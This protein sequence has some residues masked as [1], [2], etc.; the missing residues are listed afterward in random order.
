MVKFCTKEWPTLSLPDGHTLP[1]EGTK[2]TAVIQDLLLYWYMQEGS[3]A[4]PIVGL[5]IQYATVWQNFARG[6]SAPSCS[7]GSNYV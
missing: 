7:D 2:D 5:N 6:I 3:I 1:P 4:D